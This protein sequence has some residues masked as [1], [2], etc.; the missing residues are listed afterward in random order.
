[1]SCLGPECGC[2]EDHQGSPSPDLPRVQD[3]VCP[4]LSSELPPSSSLPSLQLA[5]YLQLGLGVQKNFLNCHTYNSVC[6][7]IKL[8]SLFRTYYNKCITLREK[9]IGIYSLDLI[10]CNYVIATYL[11]CVR[12]RETIINP[13]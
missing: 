9:K 12:E 5:L 10:L 3:A 11:M 1:M 13:H 6:V 2:R 8:R 7:Y 4:L